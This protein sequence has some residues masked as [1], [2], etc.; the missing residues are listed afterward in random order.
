MP[1]LKQVNGRTASAIRTLGAYTTREKDLLVSEMA[2]V[3]GLMPLLMKRR[4]RQP[5]TRE[6]KAELSVHLKRLS[7]LSPYLAV[8]MLPG[9]LLMLPA[10]AWWLDRRRNRS[11]PRRT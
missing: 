5:W 6:D 2:Q 1:T 11:R 4:N 7:R 10:L 8:L 9:G 3:R